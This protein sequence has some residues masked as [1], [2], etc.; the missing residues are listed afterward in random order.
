MIWI[1]IISCFLYVIIELFC[2]YATTWKNVVYYLLNIPKKYSRIVVPVWV[3]DGS[4]LWGWGVMVFYAVSFLCCW[5]CNEDKEGIK[6]WLLAAPTIFL[7]ISVFLHGKIDDT[8]FY[9]KIYSKRMYIRMLE[10]IKRHSIH[11][12]HRHSLLYTP[13]CLSYIASSVNAQI[14]RLELSCKN[15]TKPDFHT[16]AYA[17]GGVNGLID[18]L[19]YCIFLGYL[20]L[21]FLENIDHMELSHFLKYESS[22]KRFSFYGDF[23]PNADLNCYDEEC[24]D[25]DY[26]NSVIINLSNKAF[27]EKTKKEAHGLAEECIKANETIGDFKIK[28]LRLCVLNAHAT[29]PG[30]S[31]KNNSGRLYIEQKDKFFEIS[32]RLFMHCMMVELLL[33]N[34][35]PE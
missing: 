32:N 35:K 13:L 9:P 29:V 1:L 33:M 34:N 19:E 5:L 23:G 20:N 15:S 14:S 31:K 12:H 10:R 22:Y 3:D 28:F 7:W 8:Y 30:F 21:F 26:S 17:P 16:P 25:F 27:L 6:N 24:F 4:G 11:Y 18:E 2:I